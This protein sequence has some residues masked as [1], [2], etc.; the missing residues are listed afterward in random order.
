M[1]GYLE[2]NGIVQCLPS[3]NNGIVAYN[4]CFNSTNS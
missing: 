3:R 1:F 4:V 2:I